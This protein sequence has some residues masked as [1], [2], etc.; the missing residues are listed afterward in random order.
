MGY[1]RHFKRRARAAQE[2]RPRSRGWRRRYY[3]VEEY[4]AGHVAGPMKVELS[5]PDA[6]ME[7]RENE[8]SVRSEKPL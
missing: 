2:K 6:P 4:S 5:G 8:A 1:L 7:R 3:T